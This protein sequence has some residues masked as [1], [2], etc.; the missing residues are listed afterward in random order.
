[1]IKVK[2]PKCRGSGKLYEPVTGR[3]IPTVRQK[4]CW[5]CHG[6]GKMLIPESPED[7]H[8]LVKDGRISAE[9]IKVKQEKGGDK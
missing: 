8:R 9:Q 2:C 7:E 6:T 3:K 4:Q 1:M 5:G